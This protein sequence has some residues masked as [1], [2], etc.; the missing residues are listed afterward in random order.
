[1]ILGCAITGGRDL[2][3]IVA[4]TGYTSPEPSPPLS[5]AITATH[6][7]DGASGRQRANSPSFAIR[8]CSRQG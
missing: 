3:Q 8:F 2:D 5:A 4:R 7:G 6:P 1:M